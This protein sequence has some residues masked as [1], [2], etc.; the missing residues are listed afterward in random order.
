MGKLL[1][2]AAIIGVVASVGGC[3]DFDGIQFSQ[4]EGLGYEPAMFDSPYG[5]GS[6]FGFGDGFPTPYYGDGPSMNWY[7]GGMPEPGWDG[8]RWDDDD[9]D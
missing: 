8:G 3:A 2:F 1:Q 9:D 5:F 6:P 4:F 7:N